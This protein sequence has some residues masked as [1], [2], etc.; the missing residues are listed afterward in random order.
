MLRR[1]VILRH[2]MPP[3][4]PRVSHWDLMLEGEDALHTWALNEQPSIGSRQFVD[5]IADH[6]KAYLEYE[7]PVSADRGR[8]TRWEHG[9]QFV[10]T[11]SESLW[12]A[13]LDGQNVRWRVRLQRVAAEA[14]SGQRWSCLFEDRED[15]DREDGASG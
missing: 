3:G 10:E 11:S 2:E 6:R 12:V 9:R 4:S 8:V 5:R 14:T 13:R 7:G 1:F 15:G